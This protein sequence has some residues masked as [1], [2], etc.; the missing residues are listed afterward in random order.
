MSDYAVTLLAD[1]N[2][3]L[4][5]PPQD[6]SSSSAW[7]YLCYAL[8]KDFNFLHDG[9]AHENNP[10]FANHFKEGDRLTRIHLYVR[11]T[12]DVKMMKVK[13]GVVD[14]SKEKPKDLDPDDTPFTHG[15]SKI[16]LADCN[17]CRTWETLEP[18]K[19]GKRWLLSQARIYPWPSANTK[20]DFPWT[21]KSV[22]GTPTTY[23]FS[24]KL[25]IE[26]EGKTWRF[27]FDPKWIL[28]SG[29]V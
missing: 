20:A 25:E 1:L 14:F 21:F 9:G 23:E 8:F 12:M 29:S 5:P 18:P 6:G 7:N 27:K 26:A 11:T 13:Q 15:V 3:A 28:D 10:D 16:K 2:K 24:I 17:Q 4:N 22:V 19:K